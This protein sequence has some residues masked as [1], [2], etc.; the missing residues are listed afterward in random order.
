MGEVQT[1]RAK[2]NISRYQALR[3]CAIVVVII[4]LT[5]WLGLANESIE[6][7]PERNYSTASEYTHARVLATYC[8]DGDDEE[9]LS[10]DVPD[11]RCVLIG[12]AK[13]ESSAGKVDGMLQLDFGSFK[14]V[15]SRR[16]YLFQTRY[17]TWQTF[18]I[19]SASSDVLTEGTWTTAEREMFFRIAL[20]DAMREAGYPEYACDRALVASGR[21]THHTWGLVF[22]NGVI[23]L[24]VLLLALW[25]LKIWFRDMPGRLRR[26]RAELE[27][28][29]AH[30]RNC[31]ECG[32]DLRAIPSARC[33]ECGTAF[34]SVRIKAAQEPTGAGDG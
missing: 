10:A 15:A 2:V 29:R 22:A 32:Y 7:P 16:G 21:F 12:S 18:T 34:D 31:L 27:L 8:F 20:A 4:A 14:P 6:R 28:A 1:D 33:P 25:W 11:I 19:R 13:E 23:I 5:L 26:W 17:F 30:P 3:R 24:I 9:V